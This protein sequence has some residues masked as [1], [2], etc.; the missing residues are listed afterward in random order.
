MKATVTVFCNNSD[1]S[2]ENTEPGN[3]IYGRMCDASH[4]SIRKKCWL[5]NTHMC[6][7]PD[8]ISCKEGELILNPR[9]EKNYQFLFAVGNTGCLCINNGR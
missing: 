6:K 7:K 2:D 9:G 1:G 3:D 5:P 4:T 8:S